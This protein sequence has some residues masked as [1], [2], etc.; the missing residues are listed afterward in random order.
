MLAVARLEAIPPNRGPSIVYNAGHETARRDRAD[1]G[2]ALA[3]FSVSARSR[4]DRDPVA[5]ISGD[6]LQPCPRPGHDV[7][8]NVLHLL[9]TGGDKPGDR[10]GLRYLLRAAGIGGRKPRIR[11]P[12]CRW[13]PDRSSRWACD[14]GTVWNTFQ[15]RGLCPGCSYQWTQ[16]TCLACQRWS[17]HQ[18]WYE[19]E[20]GSGKQA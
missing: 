5:A 9:D 7:P 13:Q 10:G 4:A 20:E 15:T 1:L 2:Q 11:C 19:R 18:S 16:T 3:L 6:R 14:C 12:L 17:P 8:M